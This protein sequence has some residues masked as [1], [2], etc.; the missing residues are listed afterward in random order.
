MN[1]W[2]DVLLRSLLFIVVLFIFTK[3]LGKKQISELSYFEYISGIT[4]GSIAAEIM[5]GLDSHFMHGV[6]GIGLLT[7]ITLL[8]DWIS[9]KSNKFSNF[10]EGKKTIV[11]K[12]G[13]ILEE[14]LKK[15]KYTFKELS[16]LLRKK[17]VF[18][19]EDVELAIL[20]ERGDISVLL[21]KEKQPLTAADIGLIT[22]QNKKSFTVIF[23]GI[24][25]E[26]A[27]SD[28]GY[29]QQWLDEQLK[30]NQVQAKDVFLFQIKSDGQIWIDYRDDK[31]GTI[32][33]NE[34]QQL[35]TSLMNCRKEIEQINENSIKGDKT[36]LQKPI[37]MLNEVIHTIK[38]ETK[39]N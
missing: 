4:T 18:N 37:D 25:D 38:M 28:S 3:I 16:S 9:I 12:E 32:Q 5:M 27:L 30:N 6:I 36:S 17:N 7:L 35:V 34:S 23:D 11:I 31:K 15:E 24:I 26:D 33:Q 39:Q 2:V 21:K 14:N 19:I 10:V 13:K 29:N 22:Q 1:S 20:E 8:V